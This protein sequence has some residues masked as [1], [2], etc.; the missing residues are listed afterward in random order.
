MKNLLKLTLEAHNEQKRCIPHCSNI[1]RSQMTCFRILYILYTACLFR[2]KCHAG[3]C[4][5]THSVTDTVNIGINI[6]EALWH[7]EWKNLIHSEDIYRWYSPLTSL[8]GEAREMIIYVFSLPG[9]CG[10]VW[11]VWTGSEEPPEINRRG[12][13]HHSGP[14]RLHQ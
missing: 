12:S 8:E 4:M 10:A 1:S 13:P 9:G 2:S 6:M 11:A 14:A 3:I 5:V 7:R